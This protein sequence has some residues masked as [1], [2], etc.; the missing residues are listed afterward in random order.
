MLNTSDSNSLMI[1]YCLARAWVFLGDFK[2]KNN[3]N[4]SVLA[5][6]VSTHV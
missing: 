6:H 1:C 5:E 2:N 4:H 3:Y